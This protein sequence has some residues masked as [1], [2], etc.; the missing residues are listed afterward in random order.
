MWWSHVSHVTLVFS[1]RCEP[2]GIYIVLSE[3]S[4]SL[5]CEWLHGWVMV[6]C[7]RALYGVIYMYTVR[8]RGTYRSTYRLQ[9]YSTSCT[10]SC[11][12]SGGQASWLSAAHVLNPMVWC[13]GRGVWGVLEQMLGG[14]LALCWAAVTRVQYASNNTAMKIVLTD[15]CTCTC[16]IHCLVCD[17]LLYVIHVCWTCKRQPALPVGHL[18]EQTFT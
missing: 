10:C 2:S 3:S 12:G 13:H 14:Q 15:V 18:V 17:D 7:L 6:Q 5:N 8:H 1:W 16:T 4:P 9:Y 11:E